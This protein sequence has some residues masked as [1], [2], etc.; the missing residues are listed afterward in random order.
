MGCGT[1]EKHR[2]LLQAT[3]NGEAAVKQWSTKFKDYPGGVEYFEELAGDD[4]FLDEVS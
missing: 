4:V 2:Y 1:I 3:P